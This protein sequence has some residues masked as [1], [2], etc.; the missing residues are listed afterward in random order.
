MKLL[1]YWESI[2]K[3]WTTFNEYWDNIR[4]AKQAFILLFYSIFA[5]IPSIG[6]LEK[7]NL[8]FEHGLFSMVGQVLI[9]IVR[10][11]FPK[12]FPF[13][14]VIEKPRKTEIVRFFGN[15][16]LSSTFGLFMTTPVIKY[17]NYEIYSPQVVGV[18][19]ALGASFEWI[20]KPLI[21]SV[22]RLSQSIQEYLSK[23]IDKLF[24]TDKN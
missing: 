15:L 5:L 17:F 16:V 22:F 6:F 14:K 4:D 18:S 8:P 2:S 7:Y 9:Y 1:K 11:N 21:K 13:N 12:W 3:Y 24:P 19:V 20:L 10:H 23:K